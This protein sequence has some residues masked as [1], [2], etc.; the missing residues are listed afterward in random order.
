MSHSRASVVLSPPRDPCRLW[1]HH[2]YISS[3]VDR[4]NVIGFSTS[5]AIVGNRDIYRYGFI[6]IRPLRPNLEMITTLASLSSHGSSN[7]I[8]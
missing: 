7:L 2:P 1:C 3:C 6:L 5:V 4:C 8:K